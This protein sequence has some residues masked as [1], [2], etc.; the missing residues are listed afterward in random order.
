MNNDFMLDFIND[1]GKSA[2]KRAV[3]TFAETA[4]SMITIGSAFTEINWV[5]IFSVAGVAA[6]ASF[7]KSIVVGMPEMKEE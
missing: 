4:L 3:W 6:V 1:F 7:L 2:L 5:H